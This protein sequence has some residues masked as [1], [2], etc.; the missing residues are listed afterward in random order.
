M[1]RFILLPLILAAFGAAAQT[2]ELHQTVSGPV[3][4]LTIDQGWDVHLVQH[5]TDSTFVVIH[6]T[7]D[8][9]EALQQNP[10]ITVRRHSMTLRKCPAL[11]RGT[12]VDIHS[13]FDMSEIVVF[14]SDIHA[15]SLMLHHGTS[16][17]SIYL[18][19]GSR[20]SCGIL[21]CISKAEVD[22]DQSVLTADTLM[23]G[24]FNMSIDNGSSFKADTYLQ[25]QLNVE[26][27]NGASDQNFAFPDTTLI[28][29][30]SDPINHIA[31]RD[32]K[33][34]FTVTG[35]LDFG[36]RS[37]SFLGRN[38]DEGYVVHQN[39]TPQVESPYFSQYDFNLRF[40]LLTEFKLSSQFSL[41]TGIEYIL[42][43]AWLWNPSKL[44]DAG[45]LQLD[46]SAASS[47][48]RNVATTQYLG[49][50]LK[51]TWKPRG[52]TLSSFSADLF[53]GH[54]IARQFAT[55]TPQAGTNNLLNVYGKPQYQNPWKLEAGIS[56]NT[57][58]AGLFK[59]WR[60]Y[61][62]ILPE[63]RNSPGLPKVHSCGME[64]L[65]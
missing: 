64:L 50:P 44:D 39:G 42:N 41:A 38:T 25:Q 26:L 58:D 21:G 8:Q 17:C 6:T 49:V 53:F 31:L 62:N 59:G 5:D 30:S 52:F 61:V 57:Y 27:Y 56:W 9:A 4:E 54:T 14:G 3:R 48:N 60:F 40:P 1:K 46:N 20:F 23:G 55:I 12:R 63:Y 32:Q 36:I 13:N 10:V 11:F 18:M 37:H 45:F 35:H 28:V 15:D 24:T 34:S 43:M 29:N 2:V 51:L 47:R 33:H 65:F 19:D 16:T 22:I 7:P